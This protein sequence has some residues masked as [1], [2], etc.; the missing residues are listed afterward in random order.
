MGGSQVLVIAVFYVN[1]FS[2]TPYNQ[3]RSS[4]QKGESGILLP[5]V[6]KHL[7]LKIFEVLSIALLY[8]VFQ[9]D[10]PERC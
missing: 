8:Q 10:E 2:F 1:G 9:R 7:L 5:E 6:L 4:G 3:N